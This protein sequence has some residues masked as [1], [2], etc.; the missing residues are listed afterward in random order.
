[1]RSFLSIRASDF[2]SFPFRL[3]FVCF[4]FSCCLRCSVRE[5]T[6]IEPIQQAHTGKE[7]ERRYTRGERHT[8]K[9]KRGEHTRQNRN[10]VQEST[11]RIL[12]KQNGKK[13]TRSRLK[14]KKKERGK[15]T[16]EIP[17]KEITGGHCA[18]ARTVSFKKKKVEEVRKYAEMGERR[19]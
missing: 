11:R 6:K 10:E 5:Q 13:T 2:Y 16:G 15:R 17:K 3:F 14:T 1:M 19:K 7:R 4:F 8:H 12:H 18:S 9:R